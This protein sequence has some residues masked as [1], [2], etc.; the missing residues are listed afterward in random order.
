[1]MQTAL[2]EPIA[3]RRL[4]PSVIEESGGEEARSGPPSRDYENSGPPQVGIRTGSD[5]V[6]DE[7]EG[8]DDMFG[9]ELLSDG[10]MDMLFDLEI[11][12]NKEKGRGEES[13]S[14]LFGS[15]GGSSSMIMRGE[16]GQE[17]ATGEAGGEDIIFST[18]DIKQDDGDEHILDESLFWS[19]SIT[20]GLEEDVEMIMDTEPD[21]VN[22]YS[23]MY[24][25]DPYVNNEAILI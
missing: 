10:E 25:D 24:L 15:G 9:E 22:G 18:G 4:R 7:D 6:V 12:R 5:D 20:D 1:M 16:E 11:M 17:D 3:S 2:Y 14:M 21:M 8:F 23:S 13:C 19:S